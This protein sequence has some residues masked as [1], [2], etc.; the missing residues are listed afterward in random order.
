M[1]VIQYN[2]DKKDDNYVI[3]LIETQKQDQNNNNNNINNQKNP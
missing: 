1:N 2:L 3:E